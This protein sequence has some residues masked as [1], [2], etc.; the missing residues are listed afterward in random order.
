VLLALAAAREERSRLPIL[1]EI[2]RTW[3]DGARHFGGDDLSA[4]YLALKPQTE[5]I[6]N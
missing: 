3:A 6:K 2:A 5:E 4:I 1:N